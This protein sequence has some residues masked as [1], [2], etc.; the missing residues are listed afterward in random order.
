MNL[1]D[2]AGKHLSIVPVPS[3]SE[4][5]PTLSVRLESSFL[6]ATSMV[7]V[8]RIALS[9][10]LLDIRTMEADG[11]GWC[12]LEGVDANFSL[13]LVMSKKG[14]L[15]ATLR[16]RDSRN[17]TDEATVLYTFNQTELPRFIRGFESL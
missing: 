3:L 15:S 6:T 14:E 10:F 11:S 8:A 12:H 9:A 4:E 5:Q 2:V 16:L 13:T 7:N 1:S 17:Y